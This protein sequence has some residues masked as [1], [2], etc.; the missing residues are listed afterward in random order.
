MPRLERIYAA[1]LY[2]L[3]QWNNHTTISNEAQCSAIFGQWLD[4]GCIGRLVPYM[5]QLRQMSR[6]HDDIADD[7]KD[8]I[9]RVRNPSDRQDVGRVRLVG[10][11]AGTE[12]L[13]AAKA[14]LRT[15]QDTMHGWWENGHYGEDWEPRKIA[16]RWVEV[17]HELSEDA[18]SGST[19]SR[20]VK[21]GDIDG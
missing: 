13:W 19:M 1:D 10:T 4:I 7:E 16:E 6:D 15:R 18:A 9:A 21:V 3:E 12:D 14:M 5:K 2:L 17:K 8:L 20:E 11:K